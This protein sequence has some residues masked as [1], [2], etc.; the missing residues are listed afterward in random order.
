MSRRAFTLVEL[1]VTIA[2]IG[3]LIALLLPAVQQVREAARRSQCSNHLRQIGL[4]L[5]N[6]HD[7]HRVFPPGYLH[8]PSPQGNAAGFGWAAMLLPYLE[9]PALYAE[10]DWNL[11]LWDDVHQAPRMRHLA[12]MLCPSDPGADGFFV[13]M[14]SEQY[15]AANY[16]GN[17]GPGDMDAAPEDRRGVFSRNSST[18]V[19]DVTD[20]LSQTFL[21]GERINGPFLRAVPHGIHTEYE[22]VW[23]GAVRDLGDPDDDHGH[24][25]LFRTARAPNALD[26]DDRDVVTHHSSGAQFLLGDG[27]VRTIGENV[28]LDLYRALSTRA[29][30]EAIG[31]F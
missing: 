30:G 1:L 22:T 11:P 2:I 13:E 9:Q 17:F 31:E 4:A 29:G 3:V 6:Y 7:A 24:M 23:S 27:A 28:N 20:G 26:S 15:A 10:F 19:A 12:V 18:S 16:V 25:V 8:R 5:H 21:I 14:G